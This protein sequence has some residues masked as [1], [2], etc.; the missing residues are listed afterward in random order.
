MNFFL[1]LAEGF[2]ETEAVVTL[3]ILRRGGLEVI[4][5][6]VTGR[7]TVTGAHG[8]AVVADQLFDE[9]DFSEAEML[10]LPGGN[11]GTENLSV[12][13]GLR[14]L[15]LRFGSEGKRM[16]AICAAPS[17]LGEL[18]LLEGKRAAVYP[19]CENALKGAIVIDAPVVKDGNIITAKGP[20]MAF[21]FGLAIVT[22]L[23]GQK[24]ADEVAA[25]MLWKG[26]GE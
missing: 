5:V 9:T 26:N 1:F 14:A 18:E 3:D 24:K 11:P 2:E 8:I 19:G 10:V 13:D 15:L 23:K 16:A 12:H 25:G 6:S 22:E 4:T 17:I 21:D 20:G 7:N